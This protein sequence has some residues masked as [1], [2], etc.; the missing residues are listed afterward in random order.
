MD[1]TTRTA[2]LTELRDLL[3]R[4]D[5]EISVDYDDCSDLHGVTGESMSVS[6]G[7]V[8]RFQGRPTFSLGKGWGVEPEDLSRL[9]ESH[10]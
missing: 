8:D 10:E 3:Q 4:Y 5:A 1:H 2:F 9:L 7:K 6:M